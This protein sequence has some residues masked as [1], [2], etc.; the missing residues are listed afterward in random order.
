M[1][2]PGHDKQI[3]ND[4]TEPNSGPVTDDAC[5]VSPVAKEFPSGD[6]GDTCK[7]SPV[8]EQFPA[9]TEPCPSVSKAED[10]EQ[11]TSPAH[12]EL[13]P[14]STTV[15]PHVIPQSEVEM[16]FT[17]PVRSEISLDAMEQELRELKKK[18]QAAQASSKQ[19][20][21]YLRNLISA[22]LTPKSAESQ[23]NI[24]R[25][26]RPY[27]HEEIG[28]K[29]KSMRDSVDENA[30]QGAS[31]AATSGTW[32][33]QTI[34]Y[35]GDRMYRFQQPQPIQ[36]QTQP[37]KV[38]GKP[39]PVSSSKVFVESVKRSEK[40][41]QEVRFEDR[42]SGG[43]NKF[44]DQGADVVKKLARYTAKIWRAP[45]FTP[46]VVLT[47]KVREIVADTSSRR[48][49]TSYTVTS[50]TVSVVEMRT[51][52]SLNKTKQ[53]HY[54]SRRAIEEMQIKLSKLNGER[55]VASRKGGRE[56]RPQ[57]AT[58]GTTG[59][60]PLKLPRDTGWTR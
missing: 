12:S 45:I 50:Y 22:N 11:A 40:K 17:V 26:D 55:F 10:E 49:V 57:S 51:G 56:L 43:S 54:E 52:E 1:P 7:V 20:L 53:T 5:E 28:E 9:Y 36:H 2:D 27:M 15:S 34:D 29:Q 46:M 24:F 58:R 60:S 44:L 8:T 42:T 6:T 18:T 4:A 16:N 30:L 13:P 23:A 41:I 19:N 39:E 32:T 37:T 47:E 3:V 38:P 21:E 35:Q 59:T 25:D 48:K 14:S 33:G 31:A